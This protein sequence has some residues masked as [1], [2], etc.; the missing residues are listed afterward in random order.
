MQNETGI[1]DEYNV[2]H[3]QHIRSVQSEEPKL[4]KTL[5][6]RSFVRHM[7]NLIEVVGESMPHLTVYSPFFGKN[8]SRVFIPPGVYTSRA[9]IYDD[10]RKSKLIPECTDRYLDQLW[11]T[12]FMHVSLK[13]WIPF[14][15]CGICTDLKEKILLQKGDMSL[16]KELQKCH[17]D[18][19]SNDRL[20]Y[21]LRSTLSEVSPNDVLS[22]IF[23][24]MDNNKTCVPRM[25]TKSK[26]T[27][28]VG[29]PMSCQLT[30]FLFH[31]RGFYGA[32][33]LPQY[34]HGASFTCTTLLKALLH[35]QQIEGRLPPVLFMQCDNCARDNKNQMMIALCAILVDMNIFNRIELSFMEVGHTHSDIDQEFSVIAN[36]VRNT[37]IYS[38]QD[39][40]D[41]VQ[42]CFLDGGRKWCHAEVVTNIVDFEAVIKP[43]VLDE[44]IGLGTFTD[45]ETNIKRSVHAFRLERGMSVTSPKDAEVV[46]ERVVGLTY[47][48]RDIGI[49]WFGHFMNKVGQQDSPIPILRPGY[50]IPSPL[51]ISKR[52]PVK[53]LSDIEDYVAAVFKPDYDPITKN[54]TSRSNNNNAERRTQATTDGPQFKLRKLQE[55]AENRS[56]GLTFWRNF[57]TEEMEFA[58]DTESVAPHVDT[59][60]PAFLSEFPTGLDTYGSALS[61]LVS[62]FTLAVLCFIDSPGDHE[63]P[64]PIPV[65]SKASVI[66]DTMNELRKDEPMLLSK[67]V[68]IQHHIHGKRSVFVCHSKDQPPVREIFNPVVDTK[69]GHILIVQEERNDSSFNRGWELAVANEDPVRYIEG[70]DADATVS[71]TYLQPCTGVTSSSWPDNWFSRKFKKSKAPNGRVWTDTLFPC[72]CVVFATEPLAS[73]PMKVPKALHKFMLGAVRQIGQWLEV[74]TGENAV[75]DALAGVEG[76]I[77]ARF[78]R[79][80]QLGDGADADDSD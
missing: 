20:R 30:G 61:S 44:L 14:A 28:G 33:S 75:Q 49:P 80:P 25:A 23:D 7:E 70:I 1:P 52:I 45:K 62:P 15:K 11:N 56:K 59:S 78:Y 36:K 41:L 26:N 69:K 72:E 39:L 6:A 77:L 58:R 4:A 12:Y 3:A 38:P 21:K 19:V 51:P 13:G 32:F 54:T 47:K 57:M 76:H 35:V 31:G 27:D 17:R 67:L 68:K 40:V 48:E 63:I 55:K 50:V 37:D 34:S 66:V 60:Q 16:L 53:N 71:I 42:G 79:G 10:F 73:E 46:I 29:E 24:A 43:A 9:S 5:I 18:S 22:V 65:M 8:V 64:L 74:N 2:T